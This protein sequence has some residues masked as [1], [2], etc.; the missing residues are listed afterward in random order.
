MYRIYTVYVYLSICLSVCLSIYLSIYLSIEFPLVALIMKIWPKHY[1]NPSKNHPKIIPKPPQNPPRSLPKS[2]QNPKRA[3][4][5]SRDQFLQIFWYFWSPQGLP[6]WSQNH[7]N[8]KIIGLISKLKTNT[9][10]KARFFWF[11]LIL[12]SENGTKMEVFLEHF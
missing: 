8:P 2:Q 4:N 3:L 9:F 6:K 11:L 5:V 10:S 1:P 7:W 12:A